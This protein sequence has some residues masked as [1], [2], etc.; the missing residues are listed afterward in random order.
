MVSHPGPDDPPHELGFVI[1]DPDDQGG[2]R[3]FA[4]FDAALEEF[5]I[6]LENLPAVREYLSRHSYREAYIP[7][8]GTY[9]AMV[10]S[11]GGPVHYINYGTIYGRKPD[12]T[13]ELIALPTNQLGRSGSSRGNSTAPKAAELCPICFL[14]MPLSGE[15]PNH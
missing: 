2:R 5:R 8:S 6:P 15:C 9:I 14:E 7:P 1:D 13:G 4:T 12:G 11:A 10:P 3:T